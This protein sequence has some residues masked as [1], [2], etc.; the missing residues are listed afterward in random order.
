MKNKAIQ[1]ATPLLLI[2]F[3]I[4]SCDPTSTKGDTSNRED[5]FQ[6][7]E[8]NSTSD[9]PPPENDESH[10][11]GEEDSSDNNQ[12]AGEPNDTDNGETQDPP[13][14]ATGES[15][16]WLRP[17]LLTLGG[18]IPVLL[19]L[20]ALIS[21]S[22]KNEKLDR[23]LRK[24]SRSLDDF[25][26]KGNSQN[27]QHNTEIREINDQINSL[28]NI[29]NSKLSDLHRQL[30]T[31]KNQNAQR[32][33]S[34]GNLQ[35]ASQAQSGYGVDMRQAHRPQPI[36]DPEEVRLLKSYYHNPQSFLSHATKVRMT[37]ET[38][39]K[40]LGGSLEKKIELDQHRTG[41]YFVISGDSGQ[42]YLVIDRDRIFNTQTLQ[43]IKKS[44][45]FDGI[46]NSAQKVRG[47]DIQVV[48]LAKVR[49]DASKW[50]LVESGEIQLP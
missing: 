46:N 36:E 21:L 23:E 42:E 25:K 37:P 2:S 6:Q 32:D 9:N 45:L 11:Q 35:Y 16:S 28:N 20:Y 7:S 30:I 24:L 3:L 31:L 1:L 40:I 4:V 27:S 14:E 15:L 8:R 19:L 33:S 22:Q 39:N 5:T 13:E 17:V 49:Q 10:N 38:V 44:R 48:K 18:G 41:E 26:Q 29:Y 50:Y 43:Q 34:M 47:Q 12:S